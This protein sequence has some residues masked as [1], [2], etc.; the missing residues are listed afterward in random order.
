MFCLKSQIR[1]KSPI[2]NLKIERVDPEKDLEALEKLENNE[3]FYCNPIDLK[4]VTYHC[5]N[6]EYFKITDNGKL[7]GDIIKKE[8]MCE[9]GF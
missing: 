4:F 9:I 5:E 1:F 3:F 6:N 2:N 7:V 8:D